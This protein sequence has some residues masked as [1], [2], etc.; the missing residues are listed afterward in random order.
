MIQYWISYRLDD[1]PQGKG[2]YG[3]RYDKL[4]QLIDELCDGNVWHSDTSLIMIESNSEIGSISEKIKAAINPKID[5]VLIRR[6][7]RQSAKY[8]GHNIDVKSLKVFMPYAT[9]A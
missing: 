2:T 8:I 9:R 1:G 6:V 3:S 4:I 5:N 7:N